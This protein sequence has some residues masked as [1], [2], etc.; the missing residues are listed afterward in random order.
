[1]NTTNTTFN[2]SNKGGADM[3]SDITY[4]LERQRIVKSDGSR[5]TALDELYWMIDNT[6]PECSEVIDEWVDDFDDD[7]DDED[8]EEGVNWEP[9][10]F[11]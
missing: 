9:L 10:H 2:K 7:F 6:D 8:L 1:M 5:F 11:N 4:D 3:E